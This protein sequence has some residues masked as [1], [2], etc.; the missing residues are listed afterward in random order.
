[1][2]VDR[3]EE[4]GVGSRDASC[5]QSSGSSHISVARILL[6]GLLGPADTGAQNTRSQGSASEIRPDAGVRW[7]AGV[8]RDRDGGG[9]RDFQPDF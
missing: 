8:G 1:M 7:N 3:W 9:C 4:V 2:A 6:C 5:G